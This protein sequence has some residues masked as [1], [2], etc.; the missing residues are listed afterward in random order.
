MPSGVSWSSPM[1]E[2]ASSRTELADCGCISQR[3]WHFHPTLVQGLTA[4]IT[5]LV[6]WG[7]PVSAV[8]D[9]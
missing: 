3:W 4:F 5:A 8:V 9:Q 6:V 2:S 1:G 7:G